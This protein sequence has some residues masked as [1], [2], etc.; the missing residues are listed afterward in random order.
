MFRIQ[1]FILYFFVFVTVKVFAQ[2]R[3]YYLDT[4]PV[5]DGF[6]DTT[7]LSFQLYDF[8]KVLKSNESNPD[9]K[10]RYYLG[11]NAKFL[12]LYIE[13][14]ADSI[15]IRDRGYQNGDGFHLVVAKPQKDLSPTDE[16]YVLGFSTEKSWC[17]KIIWYYNVDLKMTKLS[18][19]TKF[20]AVSKNGKISFELL[21]PW[22]DVYPYHPWFSE[23]IGFNL[24][25]VK[26]IQDKE[27]NYYF[28][29]E[30]DKIQ[31]EQSKR[32]Y[33][34]LNFERPHSITHQFSSQLLKNNIKEK[35]KLTVR[36]AGFSN[37][38]T[39]KNFTVY[40][41]SGE[42]SIAAYYN[43]SIKFKAGLS[44]T[45][46]IVENEELIPGGYTVRV[47]C[48]KELIGE[49]Y[50]TVFPET[51]TE[52]FRNILHSLAS[53]VSPGTYNTLMFYINDIDSSL[54]QLKDY[55]CSFAIRDKIAKVDSYI[56][57]LK[58]GNNPISH[59][60]GVFRRAYLSKMDNKLYPYSIYI[61]DNYREDKKFPL[62]VYLHGSGDDDR[63]LF[64][65]TLIPKEGFIVL[66]PTGRGTSNCF[67][68]TIPQT[69]IAES[70][71]DVIE[72]YYIDTTKIILSGFSMGGYGVYRTFYE[73]P[74][75][76]IALAVISGHPDLA[77]SWTDNPDEI[78]FL[79]DK[80]LTKFTGVP[81]FIFHSI[82]D[83]N[84]PY[85]LTEQLVNKLRKNGCNVVF[86]TDKTGHGNIS[87][88]FLKKY[89]DW[90]KKQIE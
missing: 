18:G 71:S 47:F 66:A 82:N 21:L 53:S 67:A 22:K 50:L 48:E 55:E 38:D 77:R 90:L 75:K 59:K 57:M 64:K 62:L 29:H 63:I 44:E 83:M 31:S 2:D 32:E 7:L 58:M 23:N 86:E 17:H 61:P 45:K 19:D 43:V 12:Y 88:A 76:Y 73:H 13:A 46:M 80:N 56:R 5:I 9:I 39:T 54:K 24:C 30:D 51:D 78:N 69:D 4:E 87:P 85:E 65:T 15:T 1:F 36:I 84:C 28:L 6:I 3:I 33:N 34:L 52:D 70:I 42:N 10:S 79:E 41:I 49:Y 27:K 26:A 35:E 40:A 8:N 25:F 60:K 72:N 11:Y 20:E 14:D 16:F 37:S 89:F 68:G 74:E 81:I